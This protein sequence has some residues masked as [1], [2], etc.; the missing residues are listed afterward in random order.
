M[1]W[2]ILFPDGKYAHL[3]ERWYPATISAPRSSN[4]GYRKHFSFHY[5]MANPSKDSRGI[6]LP[7]RINFRPIIRIDHDR[8]GPHLHFDGED[9]IQQI[10]VQG[11]TI[12][13]A[14]PFDFMRAVLEHRATNANFDAVM[15]FQVKL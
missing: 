8:W 7:D 5:G 4:W 15:K 14:D 2:A 9:H 13:D 3:K 6:P 10:R 1:D 11:M 12:D